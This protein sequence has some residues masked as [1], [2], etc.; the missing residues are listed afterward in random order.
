MQKKRT[1]KVQFKEKNVRYYSPGQNVN[2]VVDLTKQKGEKRDSVNL[3]KANS[4][5][6]ET[7]QQTLP[8]YHKEPKAPEEKTFIDHKNS[9][10]TFLTNHTN[11]NEKSLLHV[12]NSTNNSALEKKGKYDSQRFMGKAS[13]SRELPTQIQWSNLQDNN[14]HYS[15]Y[16]LLEQG[17]TMVVKKPPE[18][19]KDI[20]KKE[21]IESKI[22]NVVYNNIVARLI[23][24]ITLG[25]FIILYIVNILL[26]FVYQHNINQASIYSNLLFNKTTHLIMIMLRYEFMMIENENT[27]FI[28]YLIEAA[29]KNKKDLND[30]E[31]N[32]KPNV[33]P[34]VFQL[35]KELDA[36]DSCSLLS[37]KFSSY[38]N[39]S[40]EDELK[41]C[42]NVGELI[43]S[44]G[45][46]K[47]ESYVLSTLIF[48][49][50]D[51]KKLANKNEDIIIKKLNDDSFLNIVCEIEY[52]L[53]KYSTILMIH[54]GKDAEQIFRSIIN[55][56]KI[57]GSFSIGMNVIFL[58][59]S[60]IFIIY[61]IKAVE[62]M[63]SWLSHK[64]IVSP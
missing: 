12:I 8:I 21:V 57:L 30:F 23:L 34:S 49:I 25:A 29:E 10:S 47:A 41:E 33:L 60:L 64:I 13:S 7:D 58:I 37:E 4:N 51:W 35:Q 42:L 27:D 38:Y 52:T 26:N 20:P 54:I 50:E 56:E 36:N 32:K 40:Y 17:N 43:N 39:S 15:K 53:R 11:E 48:L 5:S 2:E 9:S 24:N 31:V 6:I 19:E 46:K 18:K 16:H 45:I 14:N 59:L 61:P 22:E 63:I 1:T 44:N 55:N 62:M 3:E 28:T